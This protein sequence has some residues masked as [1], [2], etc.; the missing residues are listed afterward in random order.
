MSTQINYQIEFF[1]D[2]HC[3][4]GLS[5]GADMDILVIKDKDGLPYIPGKTLKGLF[6]EAIEDILSFKKKG[7]ESEE[8]KLFQKSFGFFKD[9]D[10]LTKGDIFFS[11]AQLLPKESKAICDNH[12]QPYLYHRISSTKIDDAGIAVTGSLR[13][14]QVT[15]PCTL[16]AYI[17]VEDVEMKEL[18]T[19]AAGYIKRLGQNRNRGLGRC[20]IILKA[21][22]VKS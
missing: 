12:L 19:Q 11:N 14:I 17:L 7:S 13:T 6:R 22:E 16:E 1:S 18:L 15:A 2:W 4:S 8:Y 5:A 9:K 21:E 3:G 10:N 20:R